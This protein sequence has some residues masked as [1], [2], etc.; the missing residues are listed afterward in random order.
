MKKL[1]A[2]N[3]GEGDR[4]GLLPKEVHSRP[5]VRSV[6]GVVLGT[7][8]ITGAI[9]LAAVKLLEG[10]AYNSGYLRIQE[11][12]SS[13]DGQNG[14]AD[15]LV[16]GDSGCGNAVVP[17]VFEQSLEGSVTER[18]TIGNMGLLDDAWLLGAHIELYGPPRKGVLLVHVYDVWQRA[19][20]PVGLLAHVPRPL[21]FWKRFEPPVDLNWQEATDLFMARHVPL[22]GARE[23]VENMVNGKLRELRGRDGG[24]VPGAEVADTARVQRDYRQ[25]IARADSTRFAIAPQ[26]LEALD[27]I[28][29]L[30][31]DNGFDVYLA[32]GPLWEGLAADPAFQRYDSEREAALAAYAR[33]NSSVH[34]IPGTMTFGLLE[35]TRTVDHIQAEPAVRYSRDL[36]TRI[37]GLRLARP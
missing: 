1:K 34:H 35:M 36:A 17:E 18:C 23:S 16:L 8:A 6:V 22:V 20:P 25:H 4:M 21:G 27:R 5:T 15:W 24:Q 19:S 9:N 7:L 31:S 26:N 37:A 10:S 3:A 11:A 2:R 13:L 33:G 14:P 29:G 28:A 12:W 32:N 30:A